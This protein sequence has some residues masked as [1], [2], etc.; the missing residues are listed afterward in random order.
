MGRSIPKLSPTTTA[1][2]ARTTA[3]TEA[4]TAPQ[5]WPAAAAAANHYKHMS[6]TSTI[7]FIFTSYFLFFQAAKIKGRRLGPQRS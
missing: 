6:H 3:Q 1:Q 7:D 5:V 4:P 2:A